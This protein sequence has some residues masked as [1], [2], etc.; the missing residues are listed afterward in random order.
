M[1]T[2]S[3]TASVVAEENIPPPMPSA[4]KRIIWHALAVAAF[5]GVLVAATIVATR[6]PGDP[7]AV[8]ALLL[9]V[10]VTTFAIAS[11]VFFYVPRLGTRRRRDSG[12]IALRRG[13][14]VAAGI[15]ALAGLRAVDALSAITAAFLVA[16]LAA[17]EGVLSARG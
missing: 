7:N 5:A 16:A 4:T 15:V 17:V 11:A 2:F 8:A 6:D 1:T 3:D 14:I 13:A 12:L 10:G 9:G